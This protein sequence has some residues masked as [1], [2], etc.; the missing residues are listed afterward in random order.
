M[1]FE[2]INKIPV[3]G[4]CSILV[5]VCKDQGL[6]SRQTVWLTFRPYLKHKIYHFITL[7]IILL[8]SDLSS[9][10]IIQASIPSDPAAG[11]GYRKRA[12]KIYSNT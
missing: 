10:A 9:H 2:V 3:V 8:H 12:G 1:E 5:V 11:V 6:I 4:N 7:N